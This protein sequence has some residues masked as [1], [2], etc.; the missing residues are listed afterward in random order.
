MK[1]I[2]K[3]KEQIFYVIS[4][5]ILIGG[6]IIRILK[7]NDSS[8]WYDEAFSGLLVRGNLVD[9]FTTDR[10]N[11][12][13]H[14]VL[15]KIWR[16]FFGDSDIALRSL[17]IV[18]SVGLIIAAFLLIKKYFGKKAAIIVTLIFS[19]SPYF[20]LY[21][22]EARS[23]IL[24]ALESL[25][26]VCLTLSILKKNSQKNL[27]RFLKQREVI[28]LGLVFLLMFATHLLSI[29]IVLALCFVLAERINPKFFKVGAGLLLFL[30]SALV[31]NGLIS[32]TYRVIPSEKTHTYW[33]N[34]PVPK[35]LGEMYYS[36]LIGVDSQSLGDQKVFKINFIESYGLIY[37][38][39][40]LFTLVL[41]TIIIWKSERENLKNI[42]KILLIFEIIVLITSFLGLNLFLPRY[43]MP[44]A[45]VWV[46]WLGAVCSQ[47]N[48]KTLFVLLFAFCI[49]HLNI[50]WVN[51]NKDYKALT[52][53]V[54]KSENRVVFKSHFDYLVVKYYLK[55]RKEIY[56]SDEDFKDSKLLPF[57]EEE[58]MVEEPH[59]GSYY[60][61]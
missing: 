18:I 25:V 29:F 54:L 37:I 5:L 51:S 12:P 39:I 57:F 45:V 7:V 2:Q 23:Y 26:A 9:L 49:L 10:N 28:C 17:S 19:F 31:L 42:S 24:L 14:F 15:L 21:S 58:F 59:D 48:L 60:D 43:L 20:I 33:L 4:T 40:L 56:F 22:I 55:D 44:L 35:D 13:I 34:N 41:P 1:L 46:I 8:F 3:H 11:P 32:G 52:N 61:F 30:L 36:F 50:D 27:I 16:M 38:L 53:Q 47:L 6:I